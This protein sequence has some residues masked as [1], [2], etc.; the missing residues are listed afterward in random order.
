[1]TSSMTSVWRHDF[2]EE[3]VPFDPAGIRTI[4]NLSLET[5]NIMVLLRKPQQRSFYDEHEDT[6]VSLCSS[7]S[8]VSE[9]DFTK[10][11]LLLPMYYHDKD[12]YTPQK[13][14]P[15]PP[16]T[17]D[18]PSFLLFGNKRT[19]Q[20]SSSSSSDNSVLPTTTTTCSAF[21]QKSIVVTL[22]R[23]RTRSLFLIRRMVWV[24][25][26]VCLVWASVHSYVQARSQVTQ[27]QAALTSHED[28]LRSH[29]RDLLDH[30]ILLLTT[31]LNDNNIDNNDE[32]WS[33]LEQELQ[34]LRSMQQRLT[35]HLS[36]SPT[37]ED[38]VP[39]DM[40]LTDLEQILF[41]QQQKRPQ[42]QPQY[43]IPRMKHTKEQRQQQQQQIMMMEPTH[44]ATIIEP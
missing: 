33:D 1:M 35:Q 39:S 25:G 34:G 28:Q 37:L 16:Q 32:L 3:F 22:K 42:Q 44:P 10:S 19:Q 7:S 2:F 6:D 14:T 21:F 13:T 20:G 11:S 40:P 9:D 27:L 15:H 5:T 31:T 17:T 23:R 41:Q 26:V 8:L 18:R 30:P 12:N 36:R 4:P 24:V 29:E 43:S 38:V